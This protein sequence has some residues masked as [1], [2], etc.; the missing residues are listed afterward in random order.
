MF[1]TVWYSASQYTSSSQLFGIQQLQT[2]VIATVWYSTTPDTSVFNYA[3]TQYTS[4][5]QLFDILPLKTPVM[6]NCLV[7]YHSR[8][9]RFSTVWYS[10]TQDTSNG[11][12]AELDIEFV[13]LLLL[14]KHWRMIE[15]K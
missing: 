5:G 4:N 1:S 11:K 15:N 3:A 12:L 10:A 13:Q 9:K 6:V 14:I 8:H 7:F 2:P